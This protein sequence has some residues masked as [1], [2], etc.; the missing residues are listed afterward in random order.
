MKRTYLFVNIVLGIIIPSANILASV[1]PGIETRSMAANA[2]IDL[3]LRQIQESQ[4]PSGR[5]LIGAT[6]G[7]WA[8]GTEQGK[9]MDREFAYVTPENDFKQSRIH[10]NPWIWDWS[11]ADA[12]KQHV[13]DHK[14]VLRIH[15]PIGPQASE[16]AKQD[17]RTAEELESNMR[18]FFTALCKR[19]NGQPQFISMDVINEIV[20]NG[21][22]HTD[23]PGANRWE[24]PWYKIGLDTDA[25]NTPLYI[26]YAFEIANDYAP[27]L[28]L[29]INQHSSPA[30][31]ASWDLIKYTVFY[32]RERGLRVDGIGWQAHVSLGWERPENLASLHNLIRWAHAHDLEFHITEQSVWLYDSFEASQDLQADTYGSILAELLSHRANGVVAW[33]TWHI[34]DAHG[35]NKELLPALFN[36]Q[37]LPKPAYYCVQDVLHRAGAVHEDFESGDFT[38]FDWE[39]SGSADW[40]VG[41]HQVLNG[42]FSAQAGIIGDNEQS[43]LT[44]KRYCTAREIQFFIK[45]SSQSEFDRL[46]FRIDDTEIYSWSGSQDWK[47][48]THPIPTGT[49][50]FS[51]SYEKNDNDSIAQDTAWLD[52]ITFPLQ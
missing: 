11:M 22:W 42:S 25:Q 32:L 41:Q 4:F 13:I 44:I 51:W 8:L 49:H 1:D 48:V 12:W 5:V 24:L 20:L 26:R 30:D 38:S 46:V 14:Q 50:V 18:R 17:H 7:S 52:K 27:D 29:I 43:T 45:V 6:T 34:S 36:T 19:Y 21:R 35:D 31:Q 9:L 37:Y 16:W 10:P 39:H 23:K 33:N 3:P 47:L 15:G 40:I 2:P 28:K